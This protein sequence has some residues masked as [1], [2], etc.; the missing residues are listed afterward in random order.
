MTPASLKRPDLHP[1][2]RMITGRR[3]KLSTVV[4]ALLCVAAV[5]CRRPVPPLPDIIMVVIDTLRVDR[6]GCYGDVTAMTP[7]L[8]R[9]AAGGV[10]FRHAYASSCWTMPSV[11]SLFTSRFPSQHRVN[12]FDSRL[13]ASEQTLAERLSRAGYN[14]AGF[15]GN[16]RLTQENGFAQGFGAWSALYPGNAKTD[17]TR[18]GAVREAVVEWLDRTDKEREEEAEQDEEQPET[19]TG[20]SD[21]THTAAGEANTTRDDSTSADSIDSDRAG[22]DRAPA[23]RAAAQRAAGDDASVDDRDKRR[24]RRETREPVFLY[25]QYMEPHGPYQ[26]PA[27]LRE[28]FAPGVPES[29]CTRVNEKAMEISQ[30]AGRGLTP[31]EVA[32]LSSLYR[33][34]VAAVDREL[35]GMFAELDSRGLLENALVV[36]TAD[37]GE[38]FLEHGAMGHGYDLYDETTRVPLIFGGPL[39]EKGVIDGN[40]S[41]VDIAPTILDFI[42]AASDRKFEGHSLF[43][44]LRAGWLSRLLRWAGYGTEQDADILLQLPRN[45]DANDARIHEAGLVRGDRKLLVEPNGHASIFDLIKDPAELKPDDSMLHTKPLL[46][47][48]HAMVDQLA[49][50]SI[51]KA[52]KVKVDEA[53]RERLRALGYQQ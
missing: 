27:D 40:V 20:V 33:A 34:E 2:T 52:E 19:E 7:F 30:Y 13:S 9:F 28:H 3:R 12:D 44:I 8:D 48:M 29:E 35:E 1:L 51:G 47:S 39:I 43:R 4:A 46:S 14:T 37:H 45:H 32:T 11:A 53:T 18:G 23:D 50:R 36:I 10:L 15:T 41:L 21:G 6:L 25:L 38:E 26:A 17:K 31:A 42:D 49:H 24:E 22:R 16:W 5:G